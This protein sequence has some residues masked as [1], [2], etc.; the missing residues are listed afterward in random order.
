MALTGKYVGKP[1][2]PKESI[3]YVVGRGAY[4]DDL[5]T[6]GLCHMVVLRSPYPRAVIKRI[7][8]D[9][10]L[11]RAKLVL[12][13]N[14]QE[15]LLRNAT[16]PANFDHKGTSNLVKLP[17]LPSNGRVNF[18]GQPVAAVVAATRYEAYDLLEAISV[19]YER[20]D[21]VMTI[22]EALRGD[23][24]IHEGLQNNVSV[25]VTYKD[26]DVDRVFSSADRIVEDEVSI[27]RT[28]PNPIETRG[29]VAEWKGNKLHVWASNQGPFRL[30]DQLAD[31][32]GL[33]RDKVVV[34][35]VDVGGAFGSKSFLYPEYVLACFA[36]MVLKRPVKWVE[37]RSEHLRS[38]IHAREVR[39]RVSLALRN[40]GKILALRGTVI[41]DIG[42]YNLF[43]NANYA[44]FI[45][46]QLTGPYDIPVGEVRAIAVFTNKTPAGPYRG[47]GRPEAAFFYE[48]MMDLVADE[49]G[50]DPIEV[51]MRNLIALEKMPYRNPFGLTLDKED[52]ASILRE[53]VKRFDYERLR[54]AVEEGRRRGKLVG[55]GVANYIEL[56]RTVLG[57]GA[58]VRLGKDGIVYVTAG[59]GPHGQYHQIV[60]RQLVADVLD[61]DI[62][63]VVYV[64]PDIEVLPAGVGTFGS[65]SAV[66]GGEAVVRAAAKLK[67]EIIAR[68][69][70]LT[71]IPKEELRLEEGWVVRRDGQRVVAIGELS[72]EEE[73]SV[74][75]FVKG[76][77]I[78]SYGVHIAVVE[79][80]RETFKLERVQYYAIDDTG[81]T[82]NPLI[83][84]AQ[85][86]GG[87]AQGISHV[88]YESVR[89]D[90][91]GALS[92]GGILEAGVA[93]AEDLRLD[94]VSE[95]YEYPSEYT[96]GSRGIGE[97]GT[98]G[99]LPCIVSAIED[100]IGIRLRSAMLTPDQLW[101]LVNRGPDDRVGLKER[102]KSEERLSGR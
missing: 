40:D 30:R 52:Y 57:E 64:N 98:I 36:A 89:Y 41:A 59:S 56:N 83:A 28:F 72:R 11:R 81:R 29:I 34:H 87:V 75:E 25:D 37:T 74:F 55:L 95:L 4:V 38:T 7:D 1:I 12:L 54:S 51:R 101:A 71:G 78:F 9:D 76:Q 73:I 27:H 23:V 13:P 32:L 31:A 26:G 19:E 88:L 15:A 49:L 92:V 16:M 102:L 90:D 21:P 22:D 24:I 60:F 66:I 33:P 77:D 42:A 96:H 80:D 43:I 2:P 14:D 68:A 69:S 53:A 61:V 20:L 84:E 82:I 97:A 50:L 35:Y 17:V 65:R 39:A 86:I 10:A 58:L 18:E 99:A 48:R 3:T 46:Q 5:K 91:G 70:R 47:A 45:A 100:A 6:D 94:V 79:L 63:S 67:D 62:G 93:A 8:C 85:I 44:P